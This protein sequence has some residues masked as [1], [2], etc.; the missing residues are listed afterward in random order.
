[1]KLSEFIMEVVTLVRAMPADNYLPDAAVWHNQADHQELCHAC[2]AGLFA[3]AKG[4]LKH[5]QTLF[6]YSTW[7]D[8]NLPQG[9]TAIIKAVDD[10]RTGHWQL[11]QENLEIP[12]KDRID[13][14]AQD[15]PEVPEKSWFE[16]WHELKTH[17]QSLEDKARQFARTG[18]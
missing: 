6:P 3:A 1:M 15:T 8:P 11:A 12:K 9:A 7:D 17:L 10:I 14:L 18:Y 4:W 5:T 16:G 2:L 13:Q